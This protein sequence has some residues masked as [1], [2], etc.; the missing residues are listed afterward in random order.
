MHAPDPSAY[1]QLL[2]IL[3]DHSELLLEIDYLRLAHVT[4]LLRPRHLLLLAV[5]LPGDVVVFP[6]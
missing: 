4:P 3:P 5:Q 2:Q 1:L 6:L